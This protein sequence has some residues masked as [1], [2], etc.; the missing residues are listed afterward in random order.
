LG[1]PVDL[2]AGLATVVVSALEGAIILC[3]IRGDLAPFDAVV[4][5]LG[6]VL[7]AACSG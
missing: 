7:D 2:A 4:G 5:E 1:V 6:P 3:R